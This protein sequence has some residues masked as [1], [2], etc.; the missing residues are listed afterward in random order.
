MEYLIIP[1]V[2]F[3][4]ALFIPFLRKTIGLLLIILG[5]LGTMTFIGAIIGI[6]M[7][8]V[9]GI[10]LFIGDNSPNVIIE[11]KNI[12]SNENERRIECPYCSELIKDTAK[13]CRYCGRDL[14]DSH[15]KKIA[16][17]FTC[18]NC[19]KVI[20]PNLD[21]CPYC[22]IELYSCDNCNSYV[23]ENDSVCYFC[24]TEFQ[25][26]EEEQFRGFLKRLL[27]KKNK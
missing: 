3:V 4:L 1:I 23:G 14:P 25:E 11:N 17:K 19:H 24:G 2:L 12:I 6:P 10:L 21:N 13:V 22:K 20:S 5:I 8:V 16:Q 27:I 18:V 9:G 15:I 26:E 7:I